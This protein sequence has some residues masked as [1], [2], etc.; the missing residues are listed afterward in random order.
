LDQPLISIVDDDEAVCQ[1]LREL[2]QALGYRAETYRSADTF[3]ASKTASSSQCI[4]TDMQMPGL[5]GLD[6]KRRLDEE[7][8]ETP[9][10]MITARLEEHLDADV[11]KI[12]VICL[13][14]KPFEVDAL[15]LCLER[16]LG[17]GDPP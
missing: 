7:A 5:S 3:L 10:I 1:A 12:G 13:L 17:L 11:L 8:C 4:I 6:L 2:V 16:A 14:R 9:V 15:I